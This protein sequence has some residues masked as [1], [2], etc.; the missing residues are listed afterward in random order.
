M[1]DS[2]LICKSEDY[3]YVFNMQNVLLSKK[4]NLKCHYISN[5]GKKYDQYMENL[6]DEKLNDLGK[7]SKFLFTGVAFRLKR[8]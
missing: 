4:Y 5:H 7:D 6:F 8:I 3:S 1:G 2:I